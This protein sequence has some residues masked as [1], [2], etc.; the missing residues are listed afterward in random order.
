MSDDA[1]PR[2]L[3]SDPTKLMGQGHGPGDFVEAYRW[4]VVS[5]SVG[6]LGVIAVVPDRALNPSGVLFGGFTG[7]YVDLMAL[8]TVRSGPS[9]LDPTAPRPRLLTV[10]MNLSYIA[11]VPGPTFRMTG[12]VE[13]RRGFR[14]YVTIRMYDNDELAVLATA[15]MQER[16]A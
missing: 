6:H 5:E 4:E 14:H 7:T 12:T 10:D 3:P 16:R 11:A 15:T 2:F 8:H 13:H 1:R 9:R